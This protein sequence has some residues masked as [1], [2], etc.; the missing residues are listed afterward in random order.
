M[1]FFMTNS[2]S[3]TATS[4]KFS[5][6]Q[7]PVMHFRELCFFYILQ[8]LCSTR[9]RDLS[10]NIW[11]RWR[12]VCL[13]FKT[14]SR[15]FSN[16]TTENETEQQKGEAPVIYYKHAVSLLFTQVTCDDSSR[17]IH[18]KCSKPGRHQLLSS[19]V[20]NDHFF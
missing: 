8:I 12:A 5:S 17:M 20:L 13:L 3:S 16:G 6:V 18:P 19:F 2:T 11:H 4:R 9:P 1:T 7:F 10:S 14:R 15:L